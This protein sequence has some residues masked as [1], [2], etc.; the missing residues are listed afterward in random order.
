MDRKRSERTL[1]DLGSVQQKKR[2]DAE[3]I[4]RK[5]LPPASVR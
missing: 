2:V 5:C 1:V 4:V 3:G